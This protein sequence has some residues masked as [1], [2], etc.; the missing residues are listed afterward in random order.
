MF[1]Y[2]LFIFGTIHT[3]LYKPAQTKQNNEIPKYTYRV[4]FYNTALELIQLPQTSSLPNIV[5]PKES[6]L[7]RTLSNKLF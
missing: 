6:K 2:Y 3:K 4:K 5:F 1:Q 7:Y